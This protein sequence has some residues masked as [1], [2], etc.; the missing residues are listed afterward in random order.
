MSGIFQTLGLLVGGYTVYGLVT[1][2][3]YAKYRSGGR[4]FRRADDGRG[5]WSAIVAYAV[6]ATMLIFV[7]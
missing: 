2:E 5:Y 4:L 1:G 3:V 7:F 6:L